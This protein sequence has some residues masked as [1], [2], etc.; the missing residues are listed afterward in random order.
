MIYNVDMAFFQIFIWWYTT[1]FVWATN[2]IKT[3]LDVIGQT[4]AIS[5][6]AKTLF[7]P[8]KQITSNQYRINFLQKMIDNGVSRFI[9]FIV[10]ISMLTIGGL[11]AIIV[12]ILGLIW[13]VIW[14]LLPFA[15]L[16]LPI[17]TVREISF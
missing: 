7:A 3:Q 5:I 13:L 14:P 2:Q 11:W 15:L 12:L 16:I 10:R 9:G 6:L 8:W 4:L 17:L 1:G